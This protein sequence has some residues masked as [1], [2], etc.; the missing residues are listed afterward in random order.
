MTGHDAID[1][2]KPHTARV[3]DWLLGGKDNHP[4]DEE[5]AK[6]IMTLDA[7]APEIARSSW[8]FM[9]RAI[10]WLAD[11]G[12]L[13]QFLDIGS[14]IPTAPNLHQT[15][16][17]VAPEARVVYTDNDPTVLRL[18]EAL[19]PGTPEG[20][21]EYV[22]ADLREPE[23]VIEAAGKTLD[24]SRPV[25]V[26][27]VGMLHFVPDEEGAYELVRRLLEP[28]TSGSW[29]VLSHVTGDFD[30][31]SAFQARGF[32]RQRGLILAPRSREEFGV[33][34][35]GLDL[36]EPGVSLVADWRSEL[37]EAVPVP[38]PG[39]APAYAGVARKL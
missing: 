37:G 25:V 26:S 12:G 39:P 5:M 22:Q 35:K 21:T 7:R 27:L 31:D 38:G 8:A 28:L 16:Q 33:F 20:A 23:A 1:I 4:A 32:F 2:T 24:L 10:R 19:L 15:A 17:A 6:R 14:G 11:A 13:R 3:Y 36:A 30:R 18:V 9:H 29:L 34:F